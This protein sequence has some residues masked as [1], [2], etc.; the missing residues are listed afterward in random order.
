MVDEVLNEGAPEAPPVENLRSTIEAAIERQRE[1]APVVEAVAE[2]APAI[3][4]EPKAGQPRTEDGKF[5]PKDLAATP[6]A[7]TPPPDAAKAVEGEQKEPAAAPDAAPRPPIGWSPSAKAQFEALPPEVKE[8]VA[9]REVEINNGFARMQE[10][11][12]LDQYIE[13]A[14]KGGTTLPE[15]LSRYGAIEDLCRRDLVQG[16]GEVCK[17]MGVS[18]RALYEELGR[19]LGATPSQPAQGQQ[20]AAAQPAAAAIPPALLQELN[21]LKQTVQ[22]FTQER[23]QAE[24][25]QRAQT[26]SQ[27]FSDP[28][29]VFAENVAE[30]MAQLI[31]LDKSNQPLTAKLKS[32]YDRATWSNPEVRALLIKQQVPSPVA[33]DAAKARQAA[34]KAQSAAKAI[35]GAP[36]AGFTPSSNAS[37]PKTIREA[38]L[39]AVTEQRGRA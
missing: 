31:S 36:A 5:A 4:A 17:N 13:R 23:Q 33:S 18:P 24:D 27:F 21:G 35:T 1:P 20:P 29:N 9:K 22:S 28:A 26:I 6:A 38:V 19:R 39:A 12:P 14:K 3:T 8:A 7:E 2:E 11:K 25:S 10:Y 15:A 32:A 30:D 34:S 37:P 16:V